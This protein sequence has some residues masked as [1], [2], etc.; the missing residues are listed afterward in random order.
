[1]QYIPDQIKGAYGKKE[2]TG[3]GFIFYE[4]NREK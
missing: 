1:M 2:N 4:Y 3:Q